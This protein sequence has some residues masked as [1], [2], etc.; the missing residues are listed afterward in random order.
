MNKTH[1]SWAI[2]AAIMLKNDEVSFH[3]I[4]MWKRVMATGLSGL[5]RLGGKT[6]K[7]TFNSDINNS[8]LFYNCG[9]RDGKHSLLDEEEAKRDPEIQAALKALNK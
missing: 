7:R 3:Y 4:D 6:S 8:D 1:P 5:E 2:T 9:D